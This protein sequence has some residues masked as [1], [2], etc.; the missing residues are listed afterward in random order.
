KMIKQKIISFVQESLSEL[1]IFDVIPDIGYP[2]YS[3]FGD[4][5]TNVAIILAK[6]L[7]RRP[8]ELALEIKERLMTRGG[9]YIK[10]VTIVT[11]GFINFR[12]NDDILLATIRNR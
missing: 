7:N 5:S 8:M 11:P 1:G 2:P 3:S 6:K 9:S 12:V 10:E 4:Y